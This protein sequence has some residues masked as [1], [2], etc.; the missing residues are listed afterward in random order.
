[1]LPV[2]VVAGGVGVSWGSRGPEGRPWGGEVRL[3]GAPRAAFEV[4]GMSSFGE[5]RTAPCY[6]L[7]EYRQLREGAR[8]TVADGRGA[9]LAVAHLG[10][11]ELVAT[12]DDRET[13]VGGVRRRLACRFVVRVPNSSRLPLRSVYEVSVG[14]VAEFDVDD[15]DPGGLAVGFVGIV[16]DVAASPFED[17]FIDV[18]IR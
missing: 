9:E 6:G 3:Y 2:L 10:A 4:L 1:M 15:T 13:G 18:R 14:S 16:G 12:P 11:G 17:E 8:V 7:G 5:R